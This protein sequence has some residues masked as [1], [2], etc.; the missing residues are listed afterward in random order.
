[1]HKQATFN[2]TEATE[3]SENPRKAKRGLTINA[4]EVGG[5]DDLKPHSTQAALSRKSA[6]T[7]HHTSPAGSH[8]SSPIKKVSK[9]KNSQKISYVF[10][11][12]TEQLNEKSQCFREFNVNVKIEKPQEDLLDVINSA[13]SELSH[14][15]RFKQLEIE[16]HQ[17]THMRESVFSERN[18]HRSV[19]KFPSRPQTAKATVP[20]GHFELMTS[21]KFTI[22]FLLKY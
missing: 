17:K 6:F 18:S 13:T 20:K 12:V 16:A 10:D 1:M 19:G 5:Y 7:S 14:S 3:P 15:Q 22:F 4:S 21:V 11:P 9:V 8:K 2:Q